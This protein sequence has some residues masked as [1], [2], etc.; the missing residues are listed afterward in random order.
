MFQAGQSQQQFLN[1]IQFKLSSLRRC[2][3]DIADS[4]AATSGIAATDL[5]TSLSFNAADAAAILSAVAD[6]NAMYE[7]W[8]QGHPIH[9]S[10]PQ[11]SSNYI[12]G[13]SS[14]QTRPV[15]VHPAAR[16]GATGM[17]PSTFRRPALIKLGFRR[18]RG[19]GVSR[20]RTIR[21]PRLITRSRGTRGMNSA[22]PARA[23]TALWLGHIRIM[24][25]L[26]VVYHGA[27]Q[28]GPIRTT[29][30]DVSQSQVGSSGRKAHK[31]QTA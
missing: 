27:C 24:A 8:T 13:A 7:Y 3:E 5:E 4:Y 15:T 25:H 23:F 22:S 11:P 31:C 21:I 14:A 29:A 26:C 16:Y 2:L 9:G 18:A 30:W 12:F 10:Y 1:S 20:A 6:A 19:I 17:S 28:D